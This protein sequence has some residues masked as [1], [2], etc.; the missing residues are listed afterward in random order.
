MKDTLPDFEDKILSVLCVGESTGQL[1]SNPRFELQVGR[2]FLVGVV[3][4][5]DSRGNWMA[6]LQMS[7]AWDRVQDYVVFDSIDDYL[8]RLIEKED[9]MDA[10]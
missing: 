8:D 2:V 3:P 4:E 7:I 9:E 5:D 10:N 6:G 1:I